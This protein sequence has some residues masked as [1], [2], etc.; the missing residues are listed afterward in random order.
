LVYVLHD[1]NILKL[2]AVCSSE[3]RAVSELHV[4][5]SQTI[6]ASIFS[7]I[8]FPAT[9]LKISA[10]VSKINC[11]PK[12][13]MNFILQESLYCLLVQFTSRQN[14]WFIRLGDYPHEIT[15]L[16]LSHIFS[17]EPS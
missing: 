7:V 11:F 4:H 13:I 3:P 12:N 14:H 17:L 10:L 5:K 6:V 8:I 1:S 9:F 15:I 16:A 2:E